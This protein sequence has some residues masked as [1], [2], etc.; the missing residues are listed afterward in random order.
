MTMSPQTW[1]NDVT[2]KSNKHGERNKIITT[3]SKKL[4]PK[5]M[6]LMDDVYQAWTPKKLILIGNLFHFSEEN[7]RMK[8][9]GTGTRCLALSG[10]RRLAY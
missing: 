6:F 4:T 10:T 2:H 8:G 1:E 3:L 5:K 7:A 9:C